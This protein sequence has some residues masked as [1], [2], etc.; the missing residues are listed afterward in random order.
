MLSAIS[1][2]WDGEARISI[3]NFLFR[4]EIPG[5]LTA[6]NVCGRGKLPCLPALEGG[7]LLPRPNMVHDYSEEF[8][9]ITWLE[10]FIT[11]PQI[12]NEN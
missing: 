3:F 11:D 5:Q 2:Q 8:V 6:G 1:I 7:V 4:A 10:Q 12:R 9:T